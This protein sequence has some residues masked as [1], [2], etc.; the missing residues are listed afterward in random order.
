MNVRPGERLG[1]FEILGQL[2][3]GG[4][5]EVYRARDTKLAREVAI[6]VLPPQLGQDPERLARFEREARMLASL[7]HPGIGAIYGVEESPYGLLLVLE[8]IPG[9]TLAER[10]GRGAL[11]VS[12]ALQ[13]ARQ[14][15][16]AVAF[17]HVNGVMHR[18][19]KPANVKCTPQ[20]TVKVLDF[21]L[22]KVLS[23][24]K[25]NIEHDDPT[26]TPVT[27]VDGA[28]L[29]TP[30]YMSPEQARG[31][32]VDR[33]TD[34]WS[35]GCLLYELLTGRRTF[36][37]ATQTDT[38]VAV[39]GDEPDWSLLPATTPAPVRSILR[40]CLQRDRDR[41]FHD[42]ADVRIEIEESSGIHDA[43]AAAVSGPGHR[44]WSRVEL[45][46][47]GV[48]VLFTIVQSVFI[49]RLPPTLSV[50]YASFGMELSLPLR[51]YLRSANLALY[52]LV[53]ALVIGFVTLRLMRVTVPRATRTG[54][55]VG[56]AAASILVTVAG[57]LF[58]ALDGMAQSMRLMTAL[59]EPAMLIERDM[60][61]LHLAGGTPDRA[62]A[63]IDPTGQ[64][65][66]FVRPARFAA[67]GRAFQ[68][69]EA[70]R[71]NGNAEAARRLYRRT[72]EA[73]VVFDEV[74][75]Q[76]LLERN[77][78]WRGFLGPEFDWALPISTLREYPDLLRKV[79]QQRL[80]EL[81]K[82]ATPR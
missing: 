39:L 28:V 45:V 14:I 63:L 20:G 70:Y 58:M 66:D 32:E 72:Q 77:A 62:I 68:L 6:K 29:G 48:I 59:T 67:P 37:R 57:L 23:Q 16:D 34:I 36:Q 81:D 31:K 80:D 71:A 33:R 69:A 10:I 55:L 1:T 35:F 30:A 65:D 13:I 47:V 3:A 27:T 52:A 60:A 43:P 74:L 4:M 15:A 26:V 24:D 75:T 51:L 25:R 64:R 17:A 79:A 56:A 49:R 7:N 78:Q 9:E 8:L 44:S 40:R 41:R 53:P 21:G 46:S 11:P 18:D 5:G 82:S 19:L 2:G 54:L 22:A 61:A 12:E 38:L 42:M 73:A 76:Q 50:M